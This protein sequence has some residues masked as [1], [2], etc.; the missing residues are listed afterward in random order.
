MSDE[1]TNMHY[2]SFHMTSIAV[3]KDYKMPYKDKNIGLE[4][5]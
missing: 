5:S 4:R 3:N 2:N 1:Q